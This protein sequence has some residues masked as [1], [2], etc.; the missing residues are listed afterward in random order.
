[1]NSPSLFHGTAEPIRVLAVDDDEIV[2]SGMEVFLTA[3]DDLEMVGMAANGE[4]AIKRCAESEPD[5][6]LMDVKMPVMDGIT[7]TRLIRQQFPKIQ[8][9]ALSAYADREMIAQV[10]AAGAFIF[11]SKNAPTE[12][13]ADSIRAARNAQR[14]GRSL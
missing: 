11:M 9:V 14:H 5:V 2:R 1:M 8:V 6:V 13:L 12:Q 7:A 4:E 10:M 3:F